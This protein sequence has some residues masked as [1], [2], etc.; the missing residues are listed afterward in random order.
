MDEVGRA[1]R[2]LQAS[3]PS[4][5]RLLSAF[6]GEQGQLGQRA[7][8]TTE[9]SYIHRDTQTKALTAIPGCCSNI[10]H[11]LMLLGVM[12]YMLHIA[13]LLAP[14]FSFLRIYKQVPHVF[15]R[16]LNADSVEQATAYACFCGGT[17]LTVSRWK[18]GPISINTGAR[19]YQTSNCR[20]QE[21][22][23]SWASAHCLVCWL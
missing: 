4:L 20:R 17:A 11:I 22:R 16:Y 2:L 23:T 8:S 13:L 14:I 9:M 7:W 15:R 12:P 5:P 18:L 21:Q 19:P 1:W 3:R 10:D 6:K